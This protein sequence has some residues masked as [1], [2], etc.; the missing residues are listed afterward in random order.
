MVAVCLLGGIFVGGALLVS[1]AMGAMFMFVIGSAMYRGLEISCGCFSVSGSIGYA[2]LICACAVI[3]A[4]IATYITVI[5]VRA[6]STSEP[7][8]QK[9]QSGL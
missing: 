1:A 5:T 3:L 2:T 8:G 6:A 7:S 9:S 4:S